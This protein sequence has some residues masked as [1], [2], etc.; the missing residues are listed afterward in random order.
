M[1][2]KH[3]KKEKVGKYFLFPPIFHAIKH[4]L[5]SDDSV[6]NYAQTPD[7]KRDYSVGSAV[8]DG[9]EFWWDMEVEDLE[10]D[11]LDMFK[12]A[13]EEELKNLKTK[14]ESSSSSLITE[15]SSKILNTKAETSSS[16]SLITAAP[17]SG[18]SWWN[19]IMEAYC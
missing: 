6:I 16:C 17:A 8:H 14:A 4:T 3:Y 5:T 12:A 18:V 15:E 19:P 9:G 11:E 7:F 13:L 1:V 2:I 10:L